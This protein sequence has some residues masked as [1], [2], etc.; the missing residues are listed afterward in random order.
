MKKSLQDSLVSRVHT[1]QVSPPN[2]SQVQGLTQPQG[3]CLN[4]EYNQMSQI[5]GF[6]QPQGPCQNIQYN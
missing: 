2:V 3:V 5:Q 6:T 1:R 4:I